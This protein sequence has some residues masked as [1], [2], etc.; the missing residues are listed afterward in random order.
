MQH[1]ISISVLH[2]AILQKA[3]R[4]R[5]SAE[6]FNKAFSISSEQTKPQEK[7]MFHS[8]PHA[9]YFASLQIKFESIHSMWK[10]QR[11]LFPSALPLSYKIFS[12]GRAASTHSSPPHCKLQTFNTELRSFTS[13]HQG[14][15][16]WK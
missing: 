9:C 15:F 16:R 10:K 2:G 12:E 5:C 6:H 4:K 7:Q 3:Q 13:S 8:A 1:L 11:S 14:L